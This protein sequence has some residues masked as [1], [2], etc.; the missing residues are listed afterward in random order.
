MHEKSLVTDLVTGWSQTL[1]KPMKTKEPQG[2]FY[3]MCPPIPASY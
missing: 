3:P 1:R 2:I